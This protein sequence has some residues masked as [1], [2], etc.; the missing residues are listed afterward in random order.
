M[1][2]V[3]KLEDD[4]GFDRA[5]EAKQRPLAK[6]DSF[7]AYASQISKHSPD[8]GM[9]AEIQ[10]FLK[11]LDS[12]LEGTGLKML[13]IDR[14]YKYLVIAGGD[15]TE[16]AY[17]TFIL[18]KTGVSSETPNE[19]V[20]LTFSKD[21]TLV[22]PDRGDNVKLRKMIEQKLNTLPKFAGANA[23]S[24]D[25]HVINATVPLDE[26]YAAY[27]LA[28]ATSAINP[29]FSDYSEAKTTAK[30][31]SF[32]AL[33]AN[34]MENVGTVV[35]PAPGEIRYA[36]TII[37]TKGITP[38]SRRSDDGINDEEFEQMSSVAVAVQ[39]LI[40]KNTRGVIDPLTGDLEN[41]AVP[42]ATISALSTPIPTLGMA[43]FGIVTVFNTLGVD[44]AWITPLLNNIGPGKNPGVLARNVH[45]TPGS[46]LAK[47][48]LTS[49]EFSRTDSARIISD[50]I[51]DNLL[52]AIDC[53]P[54]AYGSQQIMPL[55]EAAR[56][57]VAAREMILKTLNVMTDGVF[58]ETYSGKMFAAV[59]DF[60]I[61]TYETKK[62]G[63]ISTSE[64]D[65]MFVG[66]HPKAEELQ[67]LVV[68]SLT[69]S[70][71]SEINKLELLASVNSTAA[72]IRITGTMNKVY[73]DGG[74]IADMVEA[75]TA[76]GVI[77]RTD[78]QENYAGQ[79]SFKV[80]SNLYDAGIGSRST[81][82]V[83]QSGRSYGGYGSRW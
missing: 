2:H 31:A 59:V 63:T 79:A 11:L 17:F 12:G 60:P 29:Y 77:I 51:D 32:G 9:S 26:E 27:V 46:E 48:D 44:K 5:G 14:T 75:F 66:D 57:S 83:S 55:L 33:R 64:I 40:M 80:L 8:K 15:N 4:N 34:V 38:R 30:L 42:V 76:V 10:D 78:I 61:G 69:N 20:R 7:D 68:E 62:N 36:T 47:I 19:C 39:P 24:L 18:A 54:Y 16:V 72:N 49:K 45:V 56:G 81:Q 13:V 82:Q 58:P 35:S 65:A 53:S 41:I 25:G 71:M 37:D 52:I 67:P 22:L 70:G 21:E 50:L 73:L 23:V 1:L 74:F 43:L 3:K 28:A 6:M